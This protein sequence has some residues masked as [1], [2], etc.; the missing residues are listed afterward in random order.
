[1]GRKAGGGTQR[2]PPRTGQRC[3]PRT[4]KP[5]A[6]PG[7]RLLRM[8]QLQLEPVAVAPIRGG[9][10]RGFGGALARHRALRPQLALLLL[11]PLRAG[12]PHGAER[13]PA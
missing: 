6:Q 9:N 4:R 8:R 2:A 10:L 7:A 5:R 3:Q 11:Q 1:M 13:T 12:R